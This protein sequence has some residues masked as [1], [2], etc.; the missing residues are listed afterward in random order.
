MNG[1]AKIAFLISIVLTLLA[2]GGGMDTRVGGGGTG[3]PVSVSVGPVTGFGSIIVNGEHYDE[4]NAEVLVDERPDRPTPATVA[5]IRL[6]MQ[7]ELQ[8]RERVVSTATVGSQLIGPV[9]SVSASSFGALGQVVVV[10][11]NPTL[12]TVFDGFGALVDLA[13]GAIVEVHGERADNGGI[14]ATRVALKPA[15]PAV[16]RLAGPASNVVGRT[17]A[18]DGLAIDATTATIVPTGATLANGQQVV[19]WTDV[20]FTGGTLVAKAMR[21]GT[22]AIANNAAVTLDGVVG[23]FTSASDFR[24]NGVPVNAAGAVFTGGNVSN[25]ANGRAVRVRGTFGN[26]VLRATNVD[27]LPSANATVQLVGNITDFVD[28]NT[29]FRIRE[30][31]ARVTPQTTYIGG[32]ANNLGSGVNVKLV[33]PLVNGI[34]EATTLEFLQATTNAQQVVFGQ[35]GA[36][37]SPV[38]L[39][40][41]RTFRLDALTV[42][43]KTTSATTYKQG[44]AADVGAGRQVKLKGSLQGGQFVAEEVQFMDS[45]GGPPPV[46]IDGI[47]SNVQATSVDVNNRTIE[48]NSATTYT[49]DGAPTTFASLKN[50]LEVDIVAIRVRGDLIAETV[51]IKSAGS[52]TASIRG[53]VSGRTPPNATLFNVGSQRV[54]VAGNPRVIP[55]NKTLA[56]IVNGS[57]IEVD[58]TIT[59][60]ILNA[61]RIKIR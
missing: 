16:V 43:V 2:C 48:L 29:A 5:A 7:I 58:G 37:V 12:P 6:G 30:T 42:D 20:P 56:D 39:D 9:S 14:F 28:A 22:T 26:G 1:S 13:S 47:A 34:V 36:P 52:G 57:D 40:G 59:A 23:N 3:A 15:A 31:L 50:G 61:T 8:H 11:A 35:V 24:V 45:T 49:L 27:F 55:G 18:I 21:V 54:N 46:E 44:V 60:G 17:F 25:L 41:S 32:G 51:E 38:A 53:I 4:T 10:N 19:V 33:G